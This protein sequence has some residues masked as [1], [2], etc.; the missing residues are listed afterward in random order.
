M[1]VL[2]DSDRQKLWA[3]FMRDCKKY[4]IIMGAYLKADLR[5]AANEYD[6]WIDSNSTSANNALSQPFKGAASVQEKTLLF[7]YVA[8]MRAGI[9]PI[10][11]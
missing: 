2:S 3:Q 4:G 9:L 5:T 6:G 8:M 11:G 7:C 10:E 1:A